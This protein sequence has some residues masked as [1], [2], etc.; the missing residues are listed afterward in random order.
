MTTDDGLTPAESAILFILMA[1]AREVSSPELKTRFKMEIRK[2][3]R[4]KL[5]GL[6]YVTSSKPGRFFVHEL[7]DAGWVRVQEDLN[8]ASSTGRALG[9]ALSLIQSNL[10]DRVLP[11]TDFTTFGEMFSQKPVV[12]AQRAELT[13][14]PEVRTDLDGRIRDAY[15]SLMSEPGAWVSLARLRG[16]LTDVPRAELDE[17]LERLSLQ[18]GV[19]LVPESNQKA[20]NADEVD[21]ALRSGGQDNHLLA[22]GV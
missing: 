8:F 21:A 12:P 14:E 1:E 16:R 18:T 9:A 17:A 22:I 4:D 19:H 10:R 2:E 7:A 15:K 13:S 3:N 5:N 20:L 11:R 6:G